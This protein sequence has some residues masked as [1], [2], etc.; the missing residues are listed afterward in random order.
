[1]LLIGPLGTNFSEILIDIYTFLRKCI[2][3]N[4][5][6]KCQPFCLGLNV[7]N[8]KPTRSGCRYRHC[9]ETFFPYL[10]HYDGIYPWPLTSR[11]DGQYCRSLIPPFLLVWTYWTLNFPKIRDYV[12]PTS[13]HFKV[14]YLQTFIR[15]Y[16]DTYIQTCIYTRTCIYMCVYVCHILLLLRL[17]NIFDTSLLTTTEIRIS[18]RD[19]EN[20]IEKLHCP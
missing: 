6:G 12:T 4:S 14:T 20:F 16:I 9:M 17:R 5:S 13:R 7:L 19:I 2:W 3:K 15:T 10:A 18:K 8:S 1:M 11:K